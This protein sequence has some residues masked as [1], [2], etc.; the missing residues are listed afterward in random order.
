VHDEVGMI[1]FVPDAIGGVRIGD[2]RMGAV[3]ESGPLQWVSNRKKY[4]ASQRRTSLHPY[5]LCA[6]PSAM[7]EVSFGAFR[8]IPLT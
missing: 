7:A 2:G 1:G 6:I 5:F 3:I 4:S 8:V